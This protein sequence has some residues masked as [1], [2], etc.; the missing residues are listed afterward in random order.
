MDGGLCRA[1]EK[2]VEGAGV[3]QVIGGPDLAVHELDAVRLQAAEGQLAAAPAE[4]V[5]TRK[6]PEVGVVA[7]EHQREARTDEARA[8]GDEDSHEKRSTRPRGRADTL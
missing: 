6:F 5:R 3:G 2:K 7:L 8:A 4:G 1:L